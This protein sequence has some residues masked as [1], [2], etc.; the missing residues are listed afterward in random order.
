MIS[1]GTQLT[2][3]NELKTLFLYYL[4]KI[5]DGKCYLKENLGRVKAETSLKVLEL[6]I[7]ELLGDVKSQLNR[8]DA[9]FAMLKSAPTKEFDAPMK[10]MI[11]NACE[12]RNDPKIHVVNDMDIMLHLQLVEHVN[13][14]SYRILK[15]IASILEYTEIEQ[16]MKECFDESKDDDKLFYAIAKEYLGD[17][18]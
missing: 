6:A 8:M 12:Y 7:D 1:T 10:T 2:D 15:K 17:R 18:T 13:L 16:L 4:N 14:V 9:V 5:Y 11:Q 3:H